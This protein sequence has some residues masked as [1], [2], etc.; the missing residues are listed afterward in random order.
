MK[1]AVLEGVEK[2]LVIK[3]VADPVPAAGFVR[4]RLQAA[5]LNHRDLWIQKGRY[6]GL[7]F[8]IILGSDGTGVV[9]A[10]GAEA[11][12]DWLDRPVIINPSLAWGSDSQAQGTGFRILGLPDDGTFAEAIAVPVM[13]L[14]PRPAHLGMEHAA[15]LPL[16]GLTAWRALF[17][18]GQLRGGETVLITGI[19]GGV[20]LLALQ[21]A[22][23]AGATVYVTSGS[24]EK[25][26]QARTLGAAGGASYRDAD[27]AAQ[28]RRR[29]GLFD[30]IVDGAMGEGFAQLIELTRPGGRIAFYGATAGNPPGFDARKVFFRQISLLGTTMGSPADFAAMVRLVEARHIVPVIDTLLPLERAEQ[31]LRRMESAAQFGKIVL[32]L[33]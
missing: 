4:V 12:D 19:G 20:A 3:Q 30:L 22:L 17:A 26:M 33:A 6:S 2:P 31:A 27:W 7:K 28:L 16:A 18:R 32:T 13:N 15:A 23:A 24:T 21:F 5:A 9:E 14:V 1:A 8:P 25:L 10:V 29:A 11:D